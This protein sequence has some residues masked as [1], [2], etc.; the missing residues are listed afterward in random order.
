MPTA[1][2]TGT[3]RGIGLALARQLAQSGHEVHAACR[4]P[5]TA[6]E[7][8]AAS[9]KLHI[10]AGVDVCDT[11]SL[12]DLAE[13]IAGPLD[14]LICNAGILRADSLSSIDGDDIRRQ[15]EV[16]ALGSL[17][18]VRAVRRRLVRGSKIGL[19]SSMM[20]SMSDNSSGGYY[21]Y[22]MSKAALNAAGVSLAR[23]LASDGIAVAVLH[24]GYVRT[25][26]TGGGGNIDTAESA[27]GLIRRMEALTLEES[28]GFWHTN[29]ERLP[30]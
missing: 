13:S 2:I 9:T 26:M 28:G 19:V 7:E 22:R 27:S 23:D 8:A 20:G 24:P 29:G 15:F 14:S 10:H 3:N 17:Q 25:E 4:A 16:N 30:W 18:T 11:E 6:L 1:L 21:G 5:S 12:E